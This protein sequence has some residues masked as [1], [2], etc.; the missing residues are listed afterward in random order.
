M[1]RCRD[2]FAP[3]FL[4]LF[5][6][7]LAGCILA[8]VDDDRGQWRDREGWNDRFSDRDGRYDRDHRDEYRATAAQVRPGAAPDAIDRSRGLSSQPIPSVTAPSQPTERLVPE[9]RQRDP[10]TGRDVVTPSYYERPGP[11]GTWQAP[12]PMSWGAPA[13]SPTRIPGR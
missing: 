5:C 6:L 1:P 10:G 2:H 9:S 7:S 12:P 3:L 13:G 8:P 11:D 4:A